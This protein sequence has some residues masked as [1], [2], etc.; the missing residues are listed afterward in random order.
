MI[1]NDIKEKL[2]EVDPIVYYGAVN[3]DRKEHIWDYI[4]FER[5]VMKPNAN[6]TGYS[7]YFSVHIIRENFIPEGIDLAVINKMRE[8]PGMKLVGEDMAY[9]YTVK[10]GTE[11][12]IEMLSIDFVRPVKV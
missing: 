4:V 5:K 2:L 1:L 7:Y 11:T 10:P 6:Q 9:T 3:K 12:V 8:I